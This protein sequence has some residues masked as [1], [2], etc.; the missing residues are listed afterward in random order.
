[1]GCGRSSKPPQSTFD[2]DQRPGFSWQFTPL[3]HSATRPGPPGVP[4]AACLPAEVLPG[5]GPLG[6]VTP[7]PRPL[8]GSHPGLLACKSAKTGHFCDPLHPKT[9][10]F[11]VFAGF[12]KSAAHGGP[13]QNIPNRA[14]LTVEREG[15]IRGWG[16]IDRHHL[17]WLLLCFLHH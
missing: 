8:P 17:Q 5:L 14:S 6:T 13:F 2:A 3:A 4:I 7:D 10:H 16:E 12:W 1:M 11:E 15:E 9:H